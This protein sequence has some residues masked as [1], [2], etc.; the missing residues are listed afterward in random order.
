[1]TFKGKT[2]AVLGA[3]AVLSGLSYAVTNY[4]MKLALD[5]EMPKVPFSGKKDGD[6]P[7][8]VFDEYAE[9]LENIPHEKVEITSSDGLK[10]AGHWFEAEHPK[11]VILAAHGWRSRWS[12]DFGYSYD[13]L[14]QQN[15][16]ILYIE[17]RGQGNSEGR[18]MGFGITER[19][20][21]VD[22]LNWINDRVGIELPVYL[23]G[24]SMGATTV[25]MASG[26]EL[27][28]NVRGIIADSGFTSPVAIWKHIAQDDM[29]LPFILENAYSRV[30]YRKKLGVSAASYSTVDALRTNR[31][32]V[33][34][35]HGQD[36]TFV[37]V[38]MTRENYAACTAPKDILIVP[39]AIHGLSYPVDEKRYQQKEIEFWS[40]YD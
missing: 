31:I 22:W 9:R 12:R 32:P 16:S 30:V 1:M 3:G 37:P 26:L 4:V 28:G 21:I 13:F 19:Y 33:L 5:R 27:P 24:V 11:R 2:A 7:Y 8:A 6:D 36:D 14:R 29:H 17:Q 15:C 39:G 25:L 18:Y 40:R 35:V 23:A 20:D 34:F 10:L 38:D